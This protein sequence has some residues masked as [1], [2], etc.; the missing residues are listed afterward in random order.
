MATPAL[1]PKWAKGMDVSQYQKD[2][3]WGRVEK[4]GL[5]HFSIV[6]AGAGQTIQDPYFIR[7]YAAVKS[8]GIP[9]GTYWF[10]Y[11]KTSGPKEEAEAY[12]KAV[13]RAGGWRGWPPMADIEQEGAG[14]L[15]VDELTD[16]LHRHLARLETLAG[17]KPV[18]YSNPSFLKTRIRANEFSQYEL[19][20][21]HYGVTQPEIPAPW[22]SARFWQYSSTGQVPGVKGHVDMNVFCG[23]LD[24]LRAWCGGG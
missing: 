13:E 15:G 21:S 19:W 17:K 23:S 5:V 2:I 4:S 6:R 9:S 1:D 18:I 11:P 16:W 8:I 24:E 12:V 20:I 14:D 3:D 10:L 22:K 7:N